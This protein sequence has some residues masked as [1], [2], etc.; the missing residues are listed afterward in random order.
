MRKS[1]RNAAIAAATILV[2]AGLGFFVMPGLMM[3]LSQ[4]S[5]WLAYAV[6]IVFILAFFGIFWLRA[7]Y[8]RKRDEREE[9]ERLR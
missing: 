2:I 8:Q 6:A 3:S 7:H 5:P 4:I 1:D 9:A